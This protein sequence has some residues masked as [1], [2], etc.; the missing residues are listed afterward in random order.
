MDP[1][2]ETVTPPEDA[3][4]VAQPPMF[5]RF[6]DPP[7]EIRHMVCNPMYELH[8][9]HKLTSHPSQVYREYLHDNDRTVFSQEW[10]EIE[11]N[12]YRASKPKWRPDL[13]EEFKLPRTF[14]NEDLPILP[15]ICL[16]NRTVRVEV[17]RFF[18]TIATFKVTTSN[19]GVNKHF[20]TAFYL[21]KYASLLHILGVS[22]S[23]HIH[24]VKFPDFNAT[25]S[26]E[27]I[28]TDVNAPHPDFYK[29]NPALKRAKK[30]N[31]AN[32]QL[33]LW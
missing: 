30:C 21:D 8:V 7:L 11:L 2:L 22:L 14:F 15:A 16:V 3:I 26:S 18:L 10:P 20:D 31:A 28:E 33:L 19:N 29:S 32:S 24:H 1:S 25:E 9:R 13:A 17:A 23:D 27:V 5:H 4:D 12:Y 6:M